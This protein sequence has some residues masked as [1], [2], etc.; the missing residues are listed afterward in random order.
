M[1]KR[2]RRSSQRKRSLRSLSRRSKLLMN[3]LK[4][5]PKL[6]LRH[7]QSPS[8]HNRQS[9]VCSIWMTCLI[10]II[11]TLGH[12]VLAASTLVVIQTSLLLLMIWASASEAI[13]PKSQHRSKMTGRMLLEAAIQAHLRITSRSTSP[14]LICIMHWRALS[15]VR[16]AMQD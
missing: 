11:T 16:K 3:Q 4:Y 10:R 8:H 9:E 12:L 13:Q 15:R 2:R 1:K 14:S 6:Q 5:S 7:S